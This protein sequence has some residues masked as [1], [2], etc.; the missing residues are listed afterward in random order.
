MPMYRILLLC[1]GWGCCYLELLDQ[2]QKQI[3]TAVDPTLA[4]SLEALTHCQCV[5]S[6]KAHCKIQDNFG[7]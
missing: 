4:V 2:L 5:A 7:S 6:L 1:L 3:C